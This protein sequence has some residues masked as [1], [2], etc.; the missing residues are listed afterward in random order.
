[1][2]CNCCMIIGH[3]YTHTHIYNI[4]IY[5]HTYKY[6]YIYYSLIIYFILYGANMICLNTNKVLVPISHITIYQNDLTTTH[7]QYSSTYNVILYRTHSIAN[8]GGGDPHQC[9]ESALQQLSKSRRSDRAP[10]TAGACVPNLFA[11][12]STKW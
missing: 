7:D 2:N 6:I 11:R 12:F 1:M 4:Y 3:T 5:T 9:V 8:A 10:Q